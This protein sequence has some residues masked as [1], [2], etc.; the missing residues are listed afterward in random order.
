MTPGTSWRDGNHSRADWE[1]RVKLRTETK[2]TEHDYAMIIGET[3]RGTWMDM[4]ILV[5]LY[6]HL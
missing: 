2:I 4:R 3:C 5:E 6:M 1:N